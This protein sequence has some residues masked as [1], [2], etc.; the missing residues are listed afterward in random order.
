MQSA[1]NHIGPLMHEACRGGLKATTRTTPLYQ[2]RAITS[3][4]TI[5]ATL[6][7]SKAAPREKQVGPS[8][9]IQGDV[10]CV[11]IMG[12]FYLKVQIIR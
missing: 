6:F 8:N 11:K 5:S 7:P 1:W 12:I 10:L 9:T 3:K 2:W 4:S